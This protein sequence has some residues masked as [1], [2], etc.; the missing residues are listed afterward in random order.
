[1]KKDDIGLLRDILDAIMRIEYHLRGM[2]ENRFAKNWTRQDAVIHQI[3]VIGE[4]A[5]NISDD[6]QE[7]HPEIPW[8]KMI[9]MR[10]KIV[11]D[12][13]NVDIQLAWDTAKNDI[14]QLKQI[15]VQLVG[16]Q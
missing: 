7:Q 5:R 3:Q 10:N 12:Y 6:F 16:E 15:I 2:N 14:P 4:V 9:G 11:H 1:M 13:G 8:P